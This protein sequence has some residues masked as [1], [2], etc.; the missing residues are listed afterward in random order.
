MLSRFATPAPRKRD[1]SRT[2]SSADVVAPLR[3]LVHRRRRYPAH[4]AAHHLH[5]QAV[6]A[7]DGLTRP[8]GDRRAGRVR[9]EAA[10][11]AALAPPAGDVD[12]R[13]PDLAGDVRRAVI[14][15]AAED[16]AAADAGADRHADHV[17]GAPRGAQPPFA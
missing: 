17:A 8:V 10:V 1:V 2:T 5:H 13:V 15:A 16:D 11:V 9:L 4:V 6:V 12:R 3:G 7:A 14:Q